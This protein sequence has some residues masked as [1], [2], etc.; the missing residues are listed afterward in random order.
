MANITCPICKKNFYRRPSYIK[1]HT[2]KI[3]CSVK[4][5]SE[6]RRSLDTLGDRTCENCGKDFRTNP[7]YIRRRPKTGGKFCSRKCF[8]EYKKKHVS[9]YRD[10]KGYLVRGR[11]RVHRIVMSEFLGRKL[12][13]D[14]HVHHINGIKDD[15]RIENL[16]LLSH[17]EH[18]VLT[19]AEK[20]KHR[21]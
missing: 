5:L 9:T 8:R 1:R 16:Q 2:G 6:Y 3:F 12:L 11:V 7:A 4:C 20:R 18:S 19:N 10:S 15:N 21:R 14:E 17:S 13:R